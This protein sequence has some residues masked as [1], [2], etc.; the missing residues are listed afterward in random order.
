MLIVSVRVFSKILDSDT[1]VRYDSVNLSDYRH[2]SRFLSILSVDGISMYIIAMQWPHCGV[3]GT[4][5]C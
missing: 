3:V 2:F 4:R 1:I 5:A